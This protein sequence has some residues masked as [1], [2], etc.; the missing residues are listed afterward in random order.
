MTILL[1]S[2]FHICMPFISFSCHTELDR[3]STMVLNRNDSREYLC[4]W[5]MLV[6]SFLIMSLLLLLFLYQGNVGLIKWVRQCS[7]Q[8][9]ERIWKEL[10]F[11]SQCVVVFTSEASWVY[12]ISIRGWIHK[13]LYTKIPI[14]FY[15]TSTFF[16]T[17]DVIKWSLKVQSNHQAARKL[18]IL[19]KQQGHSQ[20][21]SEFKLWVALESSQTSSLNYGTV[22][23]RPCGEVIL[24]ELLE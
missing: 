23:P 10:V 17:I 2:F 24:T 9:S 12:W 7:F 5:G 6:Y 1:I 21:A 20:S 8:F 19:Q 18:A 15:G 22:Y 3:T 13:S 4:L 14:W 16:G 11:F